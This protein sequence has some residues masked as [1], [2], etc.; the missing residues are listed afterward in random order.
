[1]ALML[2]NFWTTN[3]KPEFDSSQPR[4]SYIPNGINR[5]AALFEILVVARFKP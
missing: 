2:V 3:S 4:N 1:M 5:L